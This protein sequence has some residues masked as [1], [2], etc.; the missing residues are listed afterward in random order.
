MNEYRSFAAEFSISRYLDGIV[1]LTGGVSVG[2][3]WFTFA[4]YSM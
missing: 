1:E 2:G 4:V 3:F